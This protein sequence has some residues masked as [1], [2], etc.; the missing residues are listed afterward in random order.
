MDYA[1]H[2]RD[3]MFKCTRGCGEFRRDRCGSFRG[4]LHCPVCRYTH[5][6]TFTG[7]LE[8][9][10]EE[11]MT[12]HK[13]L[14][15]TGYQSTQSDFRVNLVNEGK[16]LEERVLRYV[17]KLKNMGSGADQRRLAI[18]VTQVELGFTQLYKA[19]FAPTG[20]RIALP[21]DNQKFDDGPT[22]V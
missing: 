10:K 8:R 6:L 22:S 14:P 18:G 5:T 13:G 11:K 1:H 16:E 21:E 2:E 9:Q 3:A 12:E 19:V 15:V 20:S 17:D 4:S 7:R